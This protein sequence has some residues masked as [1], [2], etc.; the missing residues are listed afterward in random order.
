MSAASSRR[1]T[2]YVSNRSVNVWM[3]SP[4]LA[5]MC[6]NP[7]RPRER[8]AVRR[9][10]RRV[11]GGPELARHPGVLGGAPAADAVEVLEREAQRVHGPVARGAGRVRAV[12]LHELAQRRRRLALAARLQVGHVGRR[13]RRRGPEQVLEHPLAAGHRRRPV[14]VGGEGQDARLPQDARPPVVGPRHPPEVVPVNV[15]NPV[16]LG[17]ALVHEGV[18]GR[19]QLGQRPVVAHLRLEE[20]LGLPLHRGAQVLV[21]HGEH[22]RVRPRVA[23]PAQPEPLGREAVGQRAPR[24]GLGQHAAH[25]GL[26]HRRLLQRSRDRRVEQLLVGDAPPEE[27][28]EPRR[29]LEVAHRIGDARLD[30]RRR[31]LDAEH[32][33]GIGEQELER[34]L[35]ARLEPALAASRLVEASQQAHV[36]VRHRAPVRAPR[37]VGEDLLGAPRLFVRACRPAH[38][39][40]LPARRRLRLD[41][42]ERP[43]DG[44]ARQGG[45]PVL[46]VV[47]AVAEG[48]GAR[49]RLED[50][51]V[52]G[53]PIE[54]RRPDQPHPRLDRQA[55]LQLV[56]G[57][58]RVRPPL[59]EPAAARAAVAGGAPRALEPAADHERLDMG[60]VDPQVELVRHVAE[61]DDVVVEVAA[62]VEL[63]EVLPVER[64]V[65]PDGEAAPRSEGQ[66]LARAVVLVLEVGHLVVGGPRAQ[67]GVADGELADA[68]RRRQVPLHQGRRDRQHLGVVVEALGV[69]VVGRQQLVD[70]HV[71]PDEVAH[72][73]AV[74][75][76]VEPVRGHR[77]PHGRTVGGGAVELGLEPRDQRRADAVVGPPHLRRRHQP[78]PH[79]AHHPLQDVGVGGDVRHVDA[80]QRHRHRATLEPAIAVAGHAVAVH[81]LARR[82]PVGHRLG[83][84]RRRR[85]AQ[86]HHGEPRAPRR[87]EQPRHGHDPPIRKSTLPA[88]AEEARRTTTRRLF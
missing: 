31:V 67:V 58:D 27:E 16:V 1:P 44:E 10:P 8:G 35:D 69:G 48:R 9:H 80:L 30:P 61:P 87:L 14:R 54:E 33:L 32:E 53:R 72:R 7:A 47:G 60:L 4:W 83:M 34:G 63:E 24:A 78:A 70:V 23:E 3:N 76:A 41:A 5:R 88:V 85:K 75:G 77:P 82:R 19:H 65:V 68:P 21:E 52:D 71:E 38:E 37:Q 26:E 56:V 11:D 28:R 62:Q 45:V 13:G 79:L 55:D 51:L 15:G 29:E 12:D 6:R 46:P 2:A 66:V 20:E 81:E 84:A 39:D 22:R 74:L 86:Q 49:P 42:V 17:E 59:G 57:V 50:P 73:V 18:V 64:E 36:A 43:G 25:L 40:A